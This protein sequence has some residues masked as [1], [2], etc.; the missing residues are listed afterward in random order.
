MQQLNVILDQQVEAP[1][2]NSEPRKKHMQAPKVEEEHLEQL[3]E[4]QREHLLAEIELA[5]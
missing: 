2:S 3:D 1:R 5:S 4:E